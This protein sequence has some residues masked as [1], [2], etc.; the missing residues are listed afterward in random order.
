MIEYSIPGHKNIRAEYLVL[1]YNGT[2]AVDGVLIP[3]V[4]DMLNRIAASL[5][6][7][8]I[9]ADTFGMARVQ[10][11]GAA[12]RLMILEPGSQ[13]L[14]KGRYISL[15]GPDKVIAVGNGRND[16]LML[17]EVAVGIAL[18]QAEG[19]SAAALMNSDI[20]C[21]SVFDAFEIILNPLRMIATLRS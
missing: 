5:E 20:I 6:V 19:A 14:Q 17:K 1:D 8:V 3:G 10:L 15:L 9:T 18:I 2:L 11:E 13:D 21:A 4:R 12:C 7:H 16:S